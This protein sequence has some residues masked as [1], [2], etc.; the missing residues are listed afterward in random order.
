M[1]ISLFTG[2]LARRTALRKRQQ[3]FLSVLVDCCGPR[4]GAI[5]ASGVPLGTV[6]RWQSDPWFAVRYAEIRETLSRDAT[7]LRANLMAK[8]V[9]MALGDYQGLAKP[10]GLRKMLAALDGAAVRAEASAELEAQIRE[11]LYG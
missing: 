1:T 9:A 6:L 8:G 3:H 10:G 7:A 4:T 5:E 11:L 2:Q